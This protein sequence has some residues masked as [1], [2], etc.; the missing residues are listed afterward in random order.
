MSRGARNAGA[1]LTAANHRLMPSN[2]SNGVPDARAAVSQD[3]ERL[4][5]RAGV[6]VLSADRASCRDC[7]RTPLI[8][9]EIHRYERGAVV[10]ELC[11]QLRAGAPVSTE[12]V[13]HSE[14][15]QTVRLRRAA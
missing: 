10:C 6:G 15:G 11:S 7:G 8:G 1:G 14:Y 3:L 9:E 12:R 4:L 13:R 5:L 2:A